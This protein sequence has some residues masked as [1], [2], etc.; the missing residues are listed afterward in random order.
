MQLRVPAN[1][2]ILSMFFAALLVGCSGKNA[3]DDFDGPPLGVGGGRKKVVKKELPS[4]GWGTLR[5]R[6]VID[7]VAPAPRSLVK[8]MKDQKDAAHCL[9]GD[10]N[11]F[12]WRVKDGGVAN[13]VVWLRAPEEYYFKIPE[14]MTKAKD[15]KIDQPYC[16][17]EPHVVVL[18][19]SYFNGQQ[20]VET[21]QKFFVYNSAPIAHNTSWQST[22]RYVTPGGNVIVPAMGDPLKI[23]VNASRPGE[24]GGEVLL[25]LSCTIHP[26]MKAFAWAFDH[27]FAAVTSG[28]RKGDK[29]YG[30]FEIKNAPAG[31][32]LQLVLWHE[33]MSA[34]RV[35]REI[36]LKEGDNGPITIKLSPNQ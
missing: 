7:G 21:G 19:P 18:Y 33:S 24:A 14:S 36:V 12:L 25:S 28:E 8:K 32:K 16:A 15:V 2:V 35:L 4:K 27:P 23:G 9:M 13:A 34:P 17:F 22:N 20:Q 1:V 31:A 6:V 29:S 3:E 26:W 5:G 10:T 30:D 11:D